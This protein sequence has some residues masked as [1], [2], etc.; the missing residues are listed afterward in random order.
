[1]RE[2]F[3][4]TAGGQVW[5]GVCGEDKPGT[6]LLVVHGDP[7]FLTMTDTVRDLADERPE[8]YKAILRE[9]LRG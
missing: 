6:P 4:P 3:I 1:M 5:Y 9:F 2:G 7:G 8:L